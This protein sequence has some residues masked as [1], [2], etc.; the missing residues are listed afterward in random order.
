AERCDSFPA[1]LV[2]EALREDVLLD[3]QVS[4]VKRGVDDVVDDYDATRRIR[5]RVAVIC[6]KTVSIATNPCATQIANQRLDERKIVIGIRIGQ[7]RHFNIA[8][9]HRGRQGIRLYAC[10]QNRPAAK[11]MPSLRERQGAHEMPVSN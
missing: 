9:P 5:Q 10:Y 4:A 11:R 2:L 6:I 1:A 3:D 8:G 7:E